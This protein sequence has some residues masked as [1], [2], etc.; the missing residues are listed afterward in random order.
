MQSLSATSP[1]GRP[2]GPVRGADPA[3]GVRLPGL[4]AVQ[5]VRRLLRR[6]VGGAVVRRRAWPPTPSTA[7]SCGSWPSLTLAIKGIAI[8]VAARRLL[9]QRL[10]AQ[11]RRRAVDRPVHLADRRRRADRVR[12]PGDPAAAAAA[13][14]G[15]GG[16][17]PAVHRG[18]PARR[19]GHGGPPAHGRPADRLADR[20][21]RRLPR[22][23]HAGRDVPVHR[24]GRHLPRPRGRSADHARVRV[25]ADPRAGQRERCR[26]ERSCADDRPGDRRRRRPAGR[27]GRGGVRRPGAAGRLG[28]RGGR[29][30]SLWPLRSALLAAQL[31]RAPLRGWAASCTWTR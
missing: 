21:E 16:G 22:R 20:G 28:R 25:R 11:T 14:R 17:G 29:W 24:R 13:R 9:M 15:G 12:L 5:P 30:P 6:A 27:R 1:A 18:D 7:S 4:E 8:P 2:A 3:A 10:A 26:A 31:H 23:D 19:A